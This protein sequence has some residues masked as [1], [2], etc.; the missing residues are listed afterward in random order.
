MKW[1]RRFNEKETC[2]E[3]IRLKALFNDPSGVCSAV[4][5]MPRAFICLTRVSGTRGQAAKNEIAMYY[6]IGMK[7]L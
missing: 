5:M 2:M 4:L 3:W 6:Y 7:Y 1:A